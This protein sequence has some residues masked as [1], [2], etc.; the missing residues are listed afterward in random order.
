M[1]SKSLFITSFPIS[2]LKRRALFNYSVK[3]VDCH[4]IENK[5]L[6]KTLIKKVIYSIFYI[7]DGF[8]L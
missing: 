3:K 2:K 5:L 7:V 1:R 4:V 6:L 8:Q